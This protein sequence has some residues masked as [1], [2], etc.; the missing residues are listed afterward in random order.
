MRAVILTLAMFC[1]APAMTPEQVEELLGQLQQPKVA[2][3]LPE[4]SD[5]GDDLEDYLYRNGLK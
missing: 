1:G 2:E 5:S 3:T 4:H